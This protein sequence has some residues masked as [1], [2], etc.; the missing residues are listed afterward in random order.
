M[1][2]RRGYQLREEVRRTTGGIAFGRALSHRFTHALNRTELLQ[3]IYSNRKPNSE[4]S[5]AEY[6]PQ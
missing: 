2:E 5:Y 6:V 3:A 1:A 4:Q